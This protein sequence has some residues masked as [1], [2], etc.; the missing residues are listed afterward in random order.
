MRVDSA[1][2]LRG[3][4]DSAQGVRQLLGEVRS[5]DPAAVAR[6]ALPAAT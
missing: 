4:G 5:E 6:A 3:S 1:G 2:V